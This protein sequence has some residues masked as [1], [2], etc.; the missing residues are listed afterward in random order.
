METSGL[1]P[2]FIFVLPI[3][4][5]LY[6]ALELNQAGQSD[7]LCPDPEPCPRLC[8]LGGKIHTWLSSKDLH[9]SGQMDQRL[10]TPLQS[11]FSCAM[12]M[13]DT[14]VTPILQVGGEPDLHLLLRPS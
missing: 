13:R 2:P 8:Y 1:P 7:L 4:Q 11:S 14:G 10:L 3:F 6:S 5:A 12:E 9:Y